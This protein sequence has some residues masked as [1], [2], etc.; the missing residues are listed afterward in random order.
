MLALTRSE[1][2]SLL[3]D[4]NYSNTSTITDNLISLKDE[5]DGSIISDK[6]DNEKFLLIG[7]ESL[8]DDDFFFNDGKMIEEAIEATEASINE[9]IETNL[10]SVNLENNIITQMD[11]ITSLSLIKITLNDIILVKKSKGFQ[12][13]LLLQASNIKINEFID[14]SFQDYKNNEFC[15][16]IIKLE[17][18]EDAISSVS[19]RLDVILTPN[20]KTDLI[21]VILENLEASLSKDSLLQLSNFFEDPDASIIS[22][23]FLLFKNVSFKIIDN[24]SKAPPISINLTETLMKKSSQNVIT[25]EPL[26]KNGKFTFF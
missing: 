23:L 1:S 18:E 14:I 25:L 22:P 9:L 24:K 11:D 20:F 17:E 21:S 8:E 19:L 15:E 12:S 2:S 3:I 4:S 10:E 26:L 7:L 16:S 5:E 6:S 13:S